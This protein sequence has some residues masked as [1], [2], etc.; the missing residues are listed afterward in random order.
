MVTKQDISNSLQ[1]MQSRFQGQRAGNMNVVVQLNITGEGGGHWYLTVKD[2]ALQINEG[3]HDPPTVTVV[4]SAD[5]WIK[6]VNR[7][8]WGESL[9]NMGR[10]Q[11]H[12]D[13][14]LVERLQ[15]LFA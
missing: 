8:A 3:Q 15:Y 12:G 10:L 11:V 7:Q 13:L 4:I 6:L 5:D 2:Q 1:A 9:Y 14:Y